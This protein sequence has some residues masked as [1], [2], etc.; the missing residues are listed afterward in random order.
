MLISQAAVAWASSG[1]SFHGHSG[2]ACPGAVNSAADAEEEDGLRRQHAVKPYRQRRRPGRV[3][4]GGRLHGQDDQAQDARCLGRAGPLASPG[5][6]AR[7]AGC[8]KG[9]ARR[10]PASGL[11]RTAAKSR[12]C[13]S[14]A[15]PTAR[16]REARRA[17][18]LPARHSG[19]R[20]ASGGHRLRRE[21]EVYASPAAGQPEWAAAGGT[22]R[23]RGGGLG[24]PPFSHRRDGCPAALDPG[25]RAV[26]RRR[27]G[28]LRRR[29]RRLPRLPQDPGAVAGAAADGTRR[30]VPPP[31]RRAPAAGAVGV[32]GPGASAPVG[33]DLACRPAPRR[34]GADGTAGPG[35]DPDPALHLPRNG[36][37]VAA[38]NV[39]RMNWQAR[40]SRL[41]WKSRRWSP[42]SDS[43]RTTEGPGRELAD[44]RPDRHTRGPVSSS[45]Q[46]K[47]NSPIGRSTSTQ[48]ERY[49]R[50][51]A[52]PGSP[53]DYE[54]RGPWRIRHGQVRRTTIS[55]F[56]WRRSGGSACLSRT[57]REVPSLLAGLNVWACC[58]A[59]AGGAGRGRHAGGWAGGAQPLP[60]LLVQP[61]ADFQVLVKVFPPVR[62]DGVSRTV[63]GVIAVPVAVKFVGVLS[64]FCPPTTL[65]LKVF[66]DGEV[67][68]PWTP[69][70][71]V[72]ETVLNFQ[73]PKLASGANCTSPVLE[74]KLTSGGSLIA[75]A[76][77]RLHDDPEGQAEF[78]VKLCLPVTSARLSVNV[79]V[80]LL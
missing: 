24:W 38:P 21:R 66:Q 41:V 54:L 13:V 28:L 39:L 75:S 33:V 42:V 53:A 73:D 58:C 35:P 1:V 51:R 14:A 48:G 36:A 23:A 4:P 43:A 11:L 40:S 65:I 16:G 72:T 78:R 55:R 77:L 22:R 59:V 10:R 57:A 25:W 19:C 64:G 31:G 67:S 46:M 17:L 52:N 5:S 9:T 62:F 7:S 50:S 80:F 29:Y 26:L 61:L 47:N 12:R 2:T 70:V 3:Y 6:G 18:A 60:A 27:A 32:A 68:P 34:T 37:S 45:A 20:G 44:P 56:W 69:L 71:V 8:R 79:R 63:P 49:C 74:S 76:L 30:G 15:S